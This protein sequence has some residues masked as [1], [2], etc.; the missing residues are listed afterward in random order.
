[1][2]FLIALAAAS[3]GYVAG[4]TFY[5]VKTKGMEPGKAALPH[6]AFWLELRALVEDG[7][8]YTSVRVAEARGGGG[9]SAA[10]GAAGG[11]A[12]TSLSDAS[13][14]PKAQKRTKKDAAQDEE[15]EEEEEDENDV[16]GG[17]E[18]RAVDESGSEDSLVE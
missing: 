18:E 13:A 1:V 17:N 9:G 12:Y 4:G 7:V 10:G 11:S 5:N 6:P 16:G 15:E 3:A 14:S 8:R 2:A